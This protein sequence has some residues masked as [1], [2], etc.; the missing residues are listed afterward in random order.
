M[1][2]ISSKKQKKNFTTMSHLPN[3]KEE[4]KKLDAS[5]KEEALRR[6]KLLYKEYEKMYHD[7]VFF[8]L[9]NKTN[10][11]DFM[12]FFV[13]KNEPMANMILE[14]M[15]LKKNDKDETDENTILV[16]DQAIDWLARI[17][18]L[19]GI[20]LDLAR[21]RPED[22]LRYWLPYMQDL[23]IV[24]VSGDGVE[25]TPAPSKPIIW[26]L[27]MA[28]ADIIYGIRLMKSGHLKGWEKLK[29]PCKF[30]QEELIELDK[31]KGKDEKKEYKDLI[32]ELEKL[33][34][35]S[36]LRNS[37]ETTWGDDERKSKPI[38]KRT[39]KRLGNLKT[40]K[41]VV[42]AG[43]N[44]E[45]SLKIE[46]VDKEDGKEPVAYYKPDSALEWLQD[47]KRRFK[48]NYLERIQIFNKYE[49]KNNFLFIPAESPEELRRFIEKN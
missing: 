30:L 9:T 44:R 1:S 28:K 37:L 48:F 4:Y 24:K 12:S 32:S 40:E 3:F 38:S 22:I 5:L 36:E 39:I 42:N 31:L 47:S 33:S 2:N 17:M 35:Y 20:E 49:D 23:G 19:L 21:F 46:M 14:L 27:L 18:Y 10:F 29:G 25:R 11:A 6:A 34:E 41:A 8:G 26:Y 45:E 13:E 15:L 16:M 7:P 43:L